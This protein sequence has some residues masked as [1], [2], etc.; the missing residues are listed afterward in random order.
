VVK[1]GDQ[2]S[3]KDLVARVLKESGGDITNAAK[4]LDIDP[5]LLQRKI[6]EHGLEDLAR[7]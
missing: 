5:T 3:E 6:A 1:A 7:P 2:F 4:Q